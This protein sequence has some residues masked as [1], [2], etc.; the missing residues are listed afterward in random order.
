MVDRHETPLRD[1]HTVTA[2]TVTAVVMTLSVTAKSD[3]SAM[4]AVVVT[5]EVIIEN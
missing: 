5:D 4:T 1:D 2:V 3:V